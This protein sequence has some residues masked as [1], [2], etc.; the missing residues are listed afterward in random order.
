MALVEAARASWPALEV[1]FVGTADGPEARLVPAHGLRFAAVAGAPYYGVGTLGR[2]RTLD[3]LVVGVAQARRVLRTVRAQLVIGLGGFASAGAVL[4]ARSLGL[5]SILYEANATAGLANRLLGRV[6]DRILLGF[7]S[8]TSDFPAERCHTTGIPVRQAVYRA[9]AMRPSPWT[10]TSGQP[11]RVLV[12]GGSQG[13]SFL[14]ARVPGL[15]RALGRR[16]V[17]CAVQHQTGDADAGAVRA[18]Y[19]GADVLAEVAPFFDD[20]GAAYERADFAITCAG[21]GTLAELAAAGIPAL[22][23]PLG[24]AARDHQRANAQAFAAVTRLWWIPEESWDEPAMAERL[25]GLATDPAALAAAGARMRSAAT[26]MAARDVLDA[27]E[28]LVRG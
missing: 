21:A 16:G 22:A 8:A 11:F 7:G 6:A 23:V 18:A 2:V 9:A 14:N 26:P 28:Q 15:L 4:A 25:A 12:L 3:R 5:P 1:T 20:V 24:C 10:A 19:A 13:S 17:P 27:C